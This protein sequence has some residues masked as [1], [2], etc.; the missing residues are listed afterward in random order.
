MVFIDSDCIHPQ[1]S[2]GLGLHTFTDHEGNKMYA[3]HQMVGAP[4]SGGFSVCVQYI[5]DFRFHLPFMLHMILLYVI[6]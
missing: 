1:V 2:L 4:V 5:D 3:V 6:N